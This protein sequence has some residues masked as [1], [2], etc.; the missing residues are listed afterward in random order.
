MICDAVFVLTKI[1]LAWLTLSFD[2][3]TLHLE[4]VSHYTSPETLR[5]S[6]HQTRLTYLL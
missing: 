3:L 6:L 4:L 5:C 1:K 2:R